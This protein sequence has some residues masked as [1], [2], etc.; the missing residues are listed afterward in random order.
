MPNKHWLIAIIIMFAIVLSFPYCHGADTWDDALLDWN[1]YLLDVNSTNYIWEPKEDITVYELALL[2]PIFAY[3]S[4][5]SVVWMIETLPL[6]AR[7]HF[8]KEE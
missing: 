2:L 5:G 7:R 6:E 3:V 4:Q 8:R 1:E